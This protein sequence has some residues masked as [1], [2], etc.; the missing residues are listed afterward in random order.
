M[1]KPGEILEQIQRIAGSRKVLIELEL[2]K[3]R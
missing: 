1:Q 3:K 2:L